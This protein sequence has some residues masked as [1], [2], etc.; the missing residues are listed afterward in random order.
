ML[1]HGYRFNTDY[2]NQNYFLKSSFKTNNAP[3]DVLATY[4]DRKFGANGFYATPA[5]VNQY[6][7]TQASLVAVQT[8]FQ[9]DNIT[10]KPRIYWRRNQDEYI[11]VR[12]I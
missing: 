12:N 10:F 6:E 11:Y 8:K 3:V 7:E 9:K 2:D 4:N 1:S 5:A